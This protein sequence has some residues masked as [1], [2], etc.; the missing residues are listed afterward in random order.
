MTR[1][2]RHRLTVALASSVLAPAAL[3]AAARAERKAAG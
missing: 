3:L 1:T 2:L